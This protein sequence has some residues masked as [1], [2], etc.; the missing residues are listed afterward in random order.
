MALALL[1]V[2]AARAA[3][4]ITIA[5]VGN[6][7]ATNWPAYIAEANGYFREL[8]VE[9]D[10]VSAPSSAASTQQVAAGSANMNTGGVADP[11]RAIDQ[12]AD[13]GAGQHALA[14]KPVQGGHDRGVREVGEGAVDV[15][16]GRRLLLAP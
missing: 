4:K 14:I 2:G 13:H 16:H 8:G 7:N 10:W 15:P 3:D 5:D 11:L 6:G 12:G 1:A 9:V